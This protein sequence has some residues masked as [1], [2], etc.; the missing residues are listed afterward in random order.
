MQREQ[1]RQAITA[2]FYQSLAESTVQVRSVPQNELQ[3]IVNALA[4]GVFAALA[5]MEAEADASGVRRVS[6]A[7]PAEDLN[8]SGAY[9]EEQLLWR[10]R[11]YLSIGTI[12]ELTNQRIRI[13]RGLLGNTIEEI[14]L[15]RVK[16][17]RVK[18]HLGERVLDVGDITVI[19]EDATMPE[20]VLNNVRDP[21]DVR[22]LIRK[23]TQE[24]KQRRGL[25]YRED[26]E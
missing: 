3:A 5:A 10:G 20:V 19:S 13:I 2:Q 25:R 17:T 6:G 14:E 15:I 16:D 4:D 8:P 9:V 12:Y 11:P 22:E 21:I 23:A 7:I 1:I 26:L 18:Q 24:E